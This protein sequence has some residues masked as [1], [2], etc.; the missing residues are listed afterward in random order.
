MLLCDVGRGVIRL[1]VCGVGAGAGQLEEGHGGGRCKP[2]LGAF[3]NASMHFET[4][5]MPLFE[6]SVALRLAGKELFHSARD[7]Y[8]HVYENSR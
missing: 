3:Q 8:R 2:S 5:A 4:P 6:L 7:E 1:L